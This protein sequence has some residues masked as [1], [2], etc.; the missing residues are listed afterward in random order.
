MLESA[1]R[2]AAGGESE[3]DLVKSHRMLSAHTQEPKLIN[4]VKAEK[5]CSTD[6]NHTL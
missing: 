2:C 1:E 3:E 5:M 4:S 6:S